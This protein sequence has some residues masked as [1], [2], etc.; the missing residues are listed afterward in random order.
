MTKKYKNLR[1]EEDIV[2]DLKKIK[3][4]YELQDNRDYTLSQIIH[5]LAED[6]KKKQF[7]LPDIDTVK[8]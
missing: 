4:L 5:L 8:H 6:R 7:V 3:R 2:D 1:V